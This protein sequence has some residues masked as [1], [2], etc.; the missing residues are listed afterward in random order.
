MEEADFLKRFARAPS[1]FRIRLVER[2]ANFLLLPD[3]VVSGWGPPLIL[4]VICFLGHNSIFAEGFETKLQI[5]FTFT[6]HWTSKPIE[7]EL[8]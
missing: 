7:V 2:A 8:T 3:S 5:Q 1:D 4:T 6:G